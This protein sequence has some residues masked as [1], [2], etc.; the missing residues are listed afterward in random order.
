VP[1]WLQLGF[2][3]CLVLGAV[4]T[5][6]GPANSFFVFGAVICIALFLWLDD[7]SLQTL[8]LKL[9]KAATFFKILGL[10]VMLTVSL[11]FLAVLTGQFQQP[12]YAISWWNASQ[13]AIWALM[14]QFMLQ[15]FFYVRMESVLGSSRAVWGTALLFSV[16]H[17]PSPLLT[18]ASFAGGVIF[19]EIFRR[20]RS[21]YPLGLIH[22]ALGLTIAASYS[23]ALLHHMRVGI[24][25]LTFH[26]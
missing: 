22:A 5:R 19:C 7:P 20:Y 11:V 1:A 24:G 15:S 10:G 17:I 26:G 13:Y 12:S 3:Y 23:D 9:P 18:V 25:Y 6:R 21:I 14:Q 2:V 8:G 4:W 16:A